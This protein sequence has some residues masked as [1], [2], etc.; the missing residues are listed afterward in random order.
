MRDDARPE[1]TMRAALLGVV[2]L[3]ALGCASTSPKPAFDDTAKAVADRLG[4]TI[5]WNEEQRA[6]EKVD[7]AV[8]DLLARPLRAAWTTRLERRSPAIWPWANPVWA[9]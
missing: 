3:L 6:S 2:A 9:I 7:H 1:D 5:E 8:A 4:A